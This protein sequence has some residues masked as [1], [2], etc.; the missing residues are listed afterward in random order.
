MSGEEQWASAAEGLVNV[1]DMEGGM[2]EEADAEAL[3]GEEFNGGVVDIDYSDIPLEWEYGYMI[4]QHGATQAVQFLLG[5]TTAFVGIPLGADV[6]RR[7][8]PGECFQGCSGGYDVGRSYPVDVWCVSAPLATHRAVWVPFSDAAPDM[9]AGAVTFDFTGE[10]PRLRWQ[11]LPP[12]FLYAVAV[13]AP[14]HE[15]PLWLV[16]AQR[17][18][19]VISAGI[20]AGRSR[21]SVVEAADVTITK[22]AATAVR[23]RSSVGAFLGGALGAASSFAPGAH[24][25]AGL[26]PPPEAPPGD[27]GKQ[28]PAK[29]PGIVP[30]AAGA[31]AV[32]AKPPARR[33]TTASLAAD[34]AELKEMIMAQQTSLDSRLRT[35]EAG[36]PPRG[37]PPPPGRSGAPPA[38]Q[39][40][41]QQQQQ[42]VA[43]SPGAPPQFRGPV[44]KYSAFGRPEM[45]AAG[46]LRGVNLGP[47]PRLGGR[48]SRPPL[49]E[50]GAGGNS[51]ARGS[52]DDYHSADGD[53]GDVQNATV[54][55][56]QTQTTLL[57]KLMKSDSDDVAM[58]LG[59][60][61]ED[62]SGGKLGGAR[63][64][65]AMEIGRRILRD[66]P[67]DVTKFVRRNMQDA[68]G[69]SLG[70]TSGADA[71]VY[72]REKGAFGGRRDMAYI[73]DIL[74]GIWNSLESKDSDAAQAQ[75]GL[76]MAAVEQY[77][78]DNRWDLAWLLTHRPDPPWAAIE[79]QQPKGTLYKPYTRLV[80]PAWVASAIAYLKDI[81]A[82]AERRSR[83]T[84]DGDSLTRAE[85][86]ALN[87]KPPPTTK[88]PDPK[89][90][91]GGGRGKG[92]GE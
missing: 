5:E 47:P 78:L 69:R 45:P 53:A 85:R 77:M 82:I 57:Q 61:T 89:A 42:P 44:P 67:I 54:A 79:R 70:Q 55:L 14:E 10:F 25:G 49:R 19:E 43:A 63:G 16:E 32:K 72:E 26:P 30:P 11:A 12:S 9:V 88:P 46:A 75:T 28:Q 50:E 71:E 51:A 92:G 80:D 41:Q 29:P 56:L 59:G 15:R 38:H 65:A 3:D 1:E 4:D 36:G 24:S 21:A 7:S 6:N 48:P 62:G 31:D 86:R 84:D 60:A 17:L 91:K 23:E 33:G 20:A 39:P 76:G 18:P 81:D 58:L 8:S 87:K 40:A 90:A 22:S 74:A 34:L 35:L 13:D 83:R 66:K 68:L 64:A 2:G 37:P 27:A 52:Q 73:F